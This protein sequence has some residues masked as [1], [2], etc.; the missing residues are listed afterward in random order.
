MAGD[1]VG[2]PRQEDSGGVSPG[3]RPRGASNPWW[4]LAWTIWRAVWNIFGA[5]G[6][7]GE[8]LDD[9]VMH[10]L[11][12]GQLGEAGEDGHVE[13]PLGGEAG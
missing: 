11:S 8:A 5:V 12:V 3:S 7:V 10:V 1:S 2:I 4:R 9:T 6:A 13:L